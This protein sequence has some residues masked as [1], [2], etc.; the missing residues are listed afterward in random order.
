MALQLYNTLTRNKEPL[1]THEE[2]RARV[3]VCGPTVY[4]Y[5]HLGHARSCI[6]YDVLVRHLRATGWTVD[7]VRNIT[8]IDDKIIKRSK[9]TGEE[10]AKLAEQFTKAYHDDMHRLQCIDPDVEPK[11]SDNL[12]AI[13][14]LV[15]RLIDKGH[16]YE[17]DGDVYFD[18]QSFEG[19][20]KLSHRNLDEL[21]AGASGRTTDE[22]SQRKRHPADFALWK[23]SPEDEPGWDSPWSRGRPGWH[24]ECSAM[25]M[26]HLG[27]SF[28][29]HG[30]GLDLV[31]PHHEN[32]IAQSEAA[33]NKT[34]ATMWVHNGFVEVDKQKMS[35]SLGNFFTVRELFERF[36]PEAIRYV[37]LT[38]HYRAPLNLD[39][40]I[41]DEGNITGFPQFEEAEHRLEYLYSTRR[42]LE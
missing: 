4:D 17:A 33:T 11:V 23:K 25:S 39:W 1:K 31:F 2:G 28:D 42:R 19:Y 36:E 37:M 24:I 21:A 8:D 27:E 10:P 5:A 41:D 35:K 30:G 29:V 13:V 38:R 15:Q 16:A 40:T 18:V 20:G 7:Y 3:Y 32:E 26:R 12:D 22:E 9:E 6:A 34:F 14:E